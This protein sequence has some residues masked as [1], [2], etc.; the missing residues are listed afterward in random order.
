MKKEVL[1]LNSAKI[2]EKK[3]LVLLLWTSGN[4][5]AIPDLL[6]FYDRYEFC[7][8]EATKKWFGDTKEKQGIVK[9]IKFLQASAID[10]VGQFVVL[11]A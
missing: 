6:I 4:Q 11:A 9:A 1:L 5:S 10:P 2:N 3:L 8:V 7:A